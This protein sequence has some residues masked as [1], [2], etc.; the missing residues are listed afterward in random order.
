MQKKSVTHRAIALFFV[1]TVLLPVFTSVNQVWA[2]N[3]GPNAPEAASFEPVDATD[4]VNLLT[5]DFSYVLPLLNV[6]SPEGGYPIALSYHGGI[7]M[8]LESSWVGLGWNLNPGAI[9]RSVNG[10][11]DDYTNTVLTD[12]F[13]DTGEEN[14][15][16]Y[17]SIGYGYGGAS[18]GV[19]FA[20][21]SHQSLSGHVSV[22]LGIDGF[23]ANLKVGYKQASSFGVG[24]NFASGLSVGTSFSSNGNIGGNAGF[25]SNGVGFNIS[26]NTNRTYGLS[27]Q[28]TGVK[29][30]NVGVNLSSEGPTL[31]ASYT[32]DDGSSQSIGIGQDYS[33]NSTLSQGDYTS[34]QSGYNVGLI[35]PTKIGVFSF[36]FGK[37]KVIYYASREKNQ[38]ITGPLYFGNAINSDRYYELDCD[39]GYYGFWKAQYATLE[40]AEAAKPRM[41]SSFECYSN[42]CCEINV[43]TTA[44]AFMDSYEVPLDEVDHHMVSKHNITSNNP[45]FPAYDTYA[46]QAQGLSGTIRPTLIDNG[47]LFGLS[48]ETEELDVNFGF[49][50]L[51]DDVGELEDHLSFR[52]RPEFYFDNEISSYLDTPKAIFNSVN[53]ALDASSIKDVF[54]RFDGQELTSNRFKKANHIEYATNAEL[55]SGTMNDT[56]FLEVNTSI[57]RADF[58]KSGIGAYKVTAA[59]G[60][61]YH[62]ALPVYNYE[63]I[64]RSYGMVSERPRECDVYLE[65]RQLEPY[66]THWLL[67]AVTGA[68]FVDNGDGIAGKGDLGYWVNFDYGLWSDAYVWSTHPDKEYIEDAEDSNI[69]TWVKG[70]KQLYYL[71]KISTRTHTAVFIKSEDDS[72]PSL[73]WE[74]KS[75]PHDNERKFCND[76]ITRFTIPSHNRLK[77]D[78]VF[79]VKN[80]DFDMDKDSGSLNSST[81]EIDLNDP[82]IPAFDVG[83]NFRE[84]VYDISDNFSSM[85]SNALKEI[86]LSQ[87]Y[88]LSN[89]QL[90]LN[91]VD[92]KGK[93]GADMIPPYRFEYYRNTN[94]TYDKEDADNWGY[95]RTDP[96]LWSLS[97]I[98]TPQGAMIDIDYEAHSFRS[99]RNHEFNIENDNFN[100]DYPDGFTFVMEYFDIP[101]NSEVNLELNYKNDFVAESTHSNGSVLT[102]SYNTVKYTGNATVTDI[103]TMNNGN[104][105]LYVTPEN[106]VTES[107]F[108]V[109]APFPVGTTLSQL[110]EEDNVPSYIRLS[111]GEDTDSFPYYD[112][113]GVRVKSI[114][115]TDGVQEF[116]SNYVYGEN[117]NGLGWVT[118]I[119]FAPKVQEEVPYSSELPPSKPMY[120]YVTHLSKDTNGNTT[121][122]TVYQYNVLKEKDLS[123]NEYDDFY[124]LDI[125]RSD[126]GWLPDKRVS[127]QE[128]TVHDHLS[129]IGQLIS[130]SNYNSQDQL[131]S[132]LTNEYYGPEELGDRMG[133][134][135]ESYQSYKKLVYKDSY[136]YDEG[137]QYWMI[138]SATRIK[139]PNLLKSS[140]EL[141][142]GVSYTTTFENFDPVLGQATQTHSKSS[143]GLEMKTETTPAFHKYPEMGSKADD[144]DNKNMLSQAAQTLSYFRELDADTWELYGAQV[145]TWK[146]WKSNIWRKHQSY[147][148][149]G[150]LETNGSYKNFVAF[151]WDASSQA[152][153]WLRISEVTRYSDYSKVLETMDIN[154][155]KMSSKLGDNYSKV[156]A[157]SN[158]SFDN[159]FYANFEYPEDFSV[160]GGT[161]GNLVKKG[162]GDVYSSGGIIDNTRAHTGNHCYRVSS[163]TDVLQVRY[164]PS[165]YSNLPQYLTYKASVWVHT[166]NYENTMVSIQEESGEKVGYT[167]REVIESGDWVLLNFYFPLNYTATNTITL[168]TTSGIAY[169]DDF[170]MHPIGKSMNTYVYNEWDELTHIMGTNNMATRYEYDAAG[171]LHKTYTEVAKNASTDGGFTLVNETNYNYK[172]L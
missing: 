109:P 100:S 123:E 141:K 72:N 131:L 116:S 47:R 162:P 41:E 153:G 30:T 4:M 154:G 97:E 17:A 122:K 45:M 33:F 63:T 114:T 60:K 104:K 115:T 159:M 51:Y 49:D 143:L 10:Y 31:L 35:I 46:I 55:L 83:Y 157:T 126:E 52:E 36:S 84:N 38:L 65:K 150:A 85:R 32:Q 37:R 121:S 87:D 111:L 82:D 134:T 98:I 9:N 5:G 75:V 138:N 91:S 95:L 127:I 163:T 164:V 80:E 26:A 8:D 155:N 160:A 148:W 74:Y 59:D 156:M 29:G 145:D 48:K 24:Y 110:R 103:V 27:I 58:P 101:L 119:P 170:R 25:D 43:I 106:D 81:T 171:R 117:D 79:L 133:I 139:Y 169:F 21:G 66:A 94:Y 137:D 86:V 118:Y 19:G 112:Q 132:K 40:E 1:F 15:S 142:N 161:F 34:N 102:Y 144:I 136:Y 73:R 149:Q 89:D 140:T 3:S 39:F 23:G 120:E 14:T 113:G 20:W 61:T 6:P 42:D 108:Y 152:D 57:N 64:T 158:A 135:K 105:L 92:F 16:Y 68:D 107:R 96:D 93:G 50:G 54:N 88:T 166:S 151:D 28:P 125:G 77:L 128:Y 62:Y 56:D 168:N 78:R 71:D 129:A 69:K 99:V 70:R 67:T 147:S 11:P 53:D 130:V 124:R 167:P 2:N 90:T 165:T 13:Y 172:N 18:V 146:A 7:P 12:Y 76:F 44:E 22:G